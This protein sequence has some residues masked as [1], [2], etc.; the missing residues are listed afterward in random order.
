MKEDKNKVVLEF[1]R[2]NPNCSSMDIFE[3]SNIDA[4]LAT[5]KRILK[6]I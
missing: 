4:G 5:I 1:I 3:K 6:K 2:N